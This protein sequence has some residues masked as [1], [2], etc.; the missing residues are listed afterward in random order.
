MFREQMAIDDILNQEDE[1]GGGETSE[2]FTL[3]TRSLFPP[4][5][6]PPLSATTP[7]SKMPFFHHL[8]I[9]A[10]R[11]ANLKRLQQNH[12]FVPQ[13]FHFDNL[14]KNLLL[15]STY[16]VDLANVEM[17]LDIPHPSEFDHTMLIEAYLCDDMSP[18]QRRLVLDFKQRREQDTTNRSMGRGKRKRPSRGKGKG[19]RNR[20]G[21][22]KGEGN[23]I[24]VCWPNCRVSR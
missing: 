23:T 5:S 18:S 1:G 24:T 4:I 15:D 22:G 19:N 16:A 6:R 2:S 9:Q 20:K 12:R 13:P 17:L 14:S 7:S 21:E 11:R 3:K 8:Q 10:Q